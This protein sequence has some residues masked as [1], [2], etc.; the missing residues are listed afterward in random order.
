MS[1]KQID[2][3]LSPMFQKKFK[4]DK[5]ENECTN[6]IKLKCNFLKC[7]KTFSNE[8]KINFHQMSH[9]SKEY[10]CSIPDCLKSFNSLYRLRIHLNSHVFVY[11]NIIEF[12]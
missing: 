4:I 2:S 6:T 5:L 12:L 1:T 11:F 10:F 7:G 3:I 9:Y 8:K